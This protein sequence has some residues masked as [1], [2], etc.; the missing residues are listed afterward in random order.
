MDKNNEFILQAIVSYVTTLETV[1][2][3]HLSDDDDSGITLQN[4]IDLYEA[5]IKG[6]NDGSWS[7][8]EVTDG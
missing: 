5:M 3:F 7:F 1:R 2:G 4:D 8:R 6:I